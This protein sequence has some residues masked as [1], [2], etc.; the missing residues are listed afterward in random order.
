MSLNPNKYPPPLFPH[1]I[2][3][4]PACTHP[5]CNTNSVATILDVSMCAVST[6]ST[7]S[8]SCQS[9]S[10]EHSAQHNECWCGQ[11]SVCHPCHRTC[12]AALQ[13]SHPHTATASVVTLAHCA[14]L[15]CVD[16]EGVECRCGD[17]LSQLLFSIV[18]FL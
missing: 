5:T 3:L 4:H 8:T 2:T 15:C 11:F 6:V 9:A 18:R 17:C 14:E 12:A 7:V 1:A 10:T 16:S 13:S